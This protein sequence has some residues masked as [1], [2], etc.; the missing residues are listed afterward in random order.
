MRALWL[1]QDPLPRLLERI[2]AESAAMTPEREALIEAQ[3]LARNG[4][5]M[6]NVVDEFL[7]G[8]RAV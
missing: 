1:E 4:V 8:I 7:N 5:T 6:Q 2:E 3:E